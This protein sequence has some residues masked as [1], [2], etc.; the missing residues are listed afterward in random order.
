MLIA[1]PECGT[2]YVVPDQALGEEGR[3]VRCAKCRHSWFQDNPAPSPAP[4]ATSPP[5]LPPREAEPPESA[6]REG[7]ADAAGREG[8]APAPELPEPPFYR[9][10]DHRRGG[11]TPEGRARDEVG[12]ADDDTREAAPERRRRWRGPVLAGALLLAL[13]AALVMSRAMSTPAWLW[14]TQPQFVAGD[15]GLTIHFPDE[16]NQ[17]RTLPDGG[18][19]LAISGTIT[20]TSRESRNVPPVLVILR[21]ARERVVYSQV[22]Q[23]PRT[24][25]APGESDEINEAIAD[26]PR[27]AVVAEFGWAPR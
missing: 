26:V 23:P 14:Q 22:I 6:P 4:P 10:S 27:S 1:C 15:P 8:G 11:D 7:V 25:L 13:A 3:T 17:T 16:R 2:R 24:R 18:E 21:D 19:F 12:E 5:P 9:P 20:N